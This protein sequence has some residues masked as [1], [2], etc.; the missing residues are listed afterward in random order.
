MLLM[1]FLQHQDTE[2]RSHTVTKVKSRVLPTDRW[3]NKS[4]LELC[5]DVMLTLQLSTIESDTAK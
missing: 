2:K 4:L 1:F 3:V 5:D